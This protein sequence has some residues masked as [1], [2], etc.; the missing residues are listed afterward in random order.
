MQNGDDAYDSDADA[1]DEF[2]RSGLGVSSAP[3]QGHFDDDHSDG[4][5]SDDGAS[6]EAE[7]TP[8]TQ[9][10]QDGE[11][12]SPLGNILL[13]S[14]EQ[15]ADFITSLSPN[16]MQYVPEFEDNA[17]SGDALVELHHEEL[18]ELGINSAGHRLTILKAVYSQKVQAGVTIEEH[19]YVPPS[20]E[21]DKDDLNA[22]QDDIS[23]V[24]ES[25]RLRDARIIAAEAELREMRRD[26]DRI[27]E[28]NRKLREET[29]PIMRLVKDRSTPLPDPV[30]ASLPSPREV[31][32][33]RESKASA[34]GRKLSAKKLWLNA[35]KQQPSPTHTNPPLT[36]REVVR[37]DSAPYLEASAAAM[38][39]SSHLT[40]SMTSSQPSPNTLFAQQHSP[41]SPAY[42]SNMPISAG[43][44]YHPT[45]SSSRSFPR[46]GS[47]RGAD[48][49]SHAT[50]LPRGDDP[51]PSHWSHASSATLAGGVDDNTGRTSTAPDRRRQQ[52]LPSPSPRDDDGGRHRER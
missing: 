51:S 36:A 24:I 48:Q 17:I 19:H 27:S 22:T 39:A 12:H 28:E 11:V 33:E 34:L 42:S 50:P 43:S 2:E 31:P 13:W 18:R 32:T 20:I 16:L 23:R 30:S 38:A 7:D 40:A 4:Q 10:W 15:V 52:P 1:D 47:S 3:K 41:T 45:S 37:D 14:V 29:L 46:E 6:V 44:S 8:T 25:I 21:G 26:L 5:E 35:P 49:R 9:A